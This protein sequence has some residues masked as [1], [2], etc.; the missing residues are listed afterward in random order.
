MKKNLKKEIEKTFTYPEP[1]DKNLLNKIYNKREFYYNKTEARPLLSNYENI[2]KIRDNI[3]GSKV[4]GAYSHQALLS[5]FINPNTPYK[6]LLLFHGTGTGKTCAAITIA[7]NFKEQVM[8]YNTKIYVL[9]PGPLIKES[10]KDALINTCTENTYIKEKNIDNLNEE[11]KNRIRKNA[12]N[13]ALQYYKF[14]SYRSFYRKV[15]GEKIKERTVVENNRSKVIYR[16][17]EEGEYERDIS[18]D[19][20]Y[21]LNN[22]LIICDEAHWLTGNYYGEALMKIIKKSTNLKIL[23]LTATPMKNL[24]DDIVEILNFIRPLDSPIQRDKIFNKEKNYLM[25]FK[26]GG[27]E[28]LKKMSRG[29]ISHLRGADPVTMAERVDNGSTP[30]GLKFTKVVGCNMSEFQR[31]LYDKV[32][33]ETDDALDR[34]SEAVANFALPGLNDSRNSIVGLYGREGMSKLINQIKTD[35]IILNKLLGKFLKKKK[36]NKRN[37]LITLS[38]N[39]KNISGKILHIDNLELFSTKFYRTL[40]NIKNN[41]FKTTSN[42]SRTGF[43]YSNL[44]KVG[45]EIYHE[46][47]LQNGFLEYQENFSSYIINDDTIDYYYGIPYSEF[48]KKYKNKTFYPATFMSITGKASEDVA[49]LQQEEKLKIVIERFNSVKNKNGK[50]IK[51]VLGSRVMNEGIS[52]RNIKEIDILDVYFNLNRVDQ[53]IGRGIRHCSHYNITNNENKYPKVEVNKYVVKTNKGLSSEEDLYRKAEDKYLLIKKVERGLKEVAI[54]CAL[55]R[56][57]NIFKEEIIEHKGC[58]KK[59]NNSCPALCDFLSCNFLCDDDILN[60]KYY[61][62]K[63]NIYKRIKSKDLD[64]T[65]FD[66][67]LS[68]NER[69]KAGN[70]IKK[71]YKTKY[72]YTLENILEN[73]KNSYKGEKRDLFDPF[74]VYLALDSMIPITENDFNNFDNIIYD[75]FNRKGYLIYINKYY[76]FQPFNQTE[77]VEMYYRKTYDKVVD[78]K[79]SLYNYMN[80]TN[81]IKNI[82]SDNTLDNIK[83]IKKKPYYDFDSVNEYYFNRKE[84]KYVGIIDIESVKKKNVNIDDINDVFKIRE[85]RNKILSKKRGTGIQSLKGAVCSTSKSREYLEIIAKKIGLNYKNI[86]TRIDLCNSIKEILLKLEKYS[87]G[88]SKMTYV[89]IPSNHKKYKFPYNLEDR[90]KYIIKKIKGLS[91]TSIRESIKKEKFKDGIFKGNIKSIKLEI[92]DNKSFNS[93]KKEL[94]KFGLKLNKKKWIIDID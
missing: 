85:K 62:P 24:A 47:L 90:Y 1:S 73:V 25:N 15:L 75:K 48:K 35:G 43:I 41:L 39:G 28:Y 78:K 14:L 91:D 55:N 57:G 66:Y 53:V 88:D 27:L 64:K 44:V 92:N 5:N 40:F 68:N 76:I 86:T 63:R 80:Y 52:L 4:K 58:E 54:D 69:D 30:K 59:K 61:D 12:L 79:I 51:V 71:L 83:N 20:I 82:K 77:D 7:E 8:K 89:M 18:I 36:Y 31:K 32:I 87:M 17:T 46:I 94:E 21:N 38:S 22:T 3:C 11:A 42:E 2:K 26:E 65:T 34:R 93:H 33:K 10:W 67:L 9:T 50:L 6:G 60:K 56:N 74:F 70:I 72:V 45:I 37:D 84:F 29:Y 49:D 19:R 16:M 13:Q 23:L 81:N